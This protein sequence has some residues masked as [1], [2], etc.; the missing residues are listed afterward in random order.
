MGVTR[1]VVACAT[2]GAYS[3]KGEVQIHHD[4]YQATT[5]VWTGRALDLRLWF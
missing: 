1:A 4:A 3:M 2:S 5:F